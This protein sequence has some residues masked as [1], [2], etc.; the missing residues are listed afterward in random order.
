MSSPITDPTAPKYHGPHPPPR[1]LLP[2]PQV[3]QERLTQDR[4]RYQPNFTEAYA[5]RILD[6]WTLQYYYE[7]TYVAYRSTPQGVEVLAAGLEE[8]GELVKSVPPEQRQ[9]VIIKQP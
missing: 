8:I 2:V 5:K 6:D 7:G 1:G 4:A 9:G 3:I